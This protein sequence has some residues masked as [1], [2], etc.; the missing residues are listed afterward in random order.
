MFG[1]RRHAPPVQPL[2]KETATPDAATA[3]ASAFLRRGSN[4]SLSSAAAAAALRARP[5]TPTNVAEVQTRRAAHRRSP[6]LSS[7]AGRDRT[8]SARDVR[9]S[10]SVSSMIERSF[11]SPSP[12]RSPAP[13]Q[14]NVPPVPALPNVHQVMADQRPKPKKSQRRPAPVQTQPFH[15][16]SEKARDGQQG[17]WF[18]RAAAGDPANVRRPDSR[19]N[20]SEPRPGSVSPSIN[21]SYP[22]AMSPSP[23]PTS[24]L[25]DDTPVYDAHTR[26]MIPKSELLA[27]SQSVREAAEKP[28]RKRQDV[29]RTGSHLS[30]GTVGRTRAPSLESGQTMLAERELAAAPAVPSTVVVA[31]DEPREPVARKKKKQSQHPVQEQEQQQQQQQARDDVTTPVPADG[32]VADPSTVAPENSARP[33]PIEMPPAVQPEP[34]LGARRGQNRPASTLAAASAAVAQPNKGKA[35]NGQAPSPS[36]KRQG[37]ARVGREA[38]QSPARSARF[39]P[40]TEQLLVRHE[41]P[42]RSVS[43]KK[44]AM[45]LPNPRDV[46]PS[47][48]DSDASE[49]GLSPQRADDPAL[50]RKK[51]VR[52]SWDDRNTVVVGEASRPEET[53]PAFLPVTQAK[54]P[55]HSI[56]TKHTKKEQQV[57]VREDETMGPRPALPLFGS[58]REKKPREA[59]ERALVRPSER[60]WSQSASAPA[61]AATELGPSSDMAVGSILA[62][63]QAS[64]NAANISKYREPLPAATHA[65]ADVN[66]KHADV[67][68]ESSDDGLDTDATTELEDITQPTQ[69]STA[70]QVASDLSEK[71]EDQVQEVQTHQADDGVPVI[72]VSHPSPHVDRSGGD[73]LGIISQP[74]LPDAIPEQDSAAGA[75]DP[76]TAAAILP[77]L[78]ALDEADAS[79]TARSIEPL[80]AASSPAM[81]DIVEEDEEADRLS[82]YS[83]ACEDLEEV[84]GDGFMSLDAVVTP[85]KGQGK[86]K[87]S[88]DQASKK[89]S[90]DAHEAT[91]SPAASK[92]LEDSPQSPKDWENAK[93]YWKSLSYNQRRQLEM[94]ALSEAGDD[95]FDDRRASRESQKQQSM[96]HQSKAAA[97]S[98]QLHNERSYQIKPGTRWADD[99]SDKVAKRASAPPNQW[100]ETGSATLK[101]PQSMRAEQPASAIRSS[102]EQPSGMRKSMRFGGVTTMAGPNG[103]AARRLR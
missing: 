52:V 12:G 26:R 85:P 89:A 21:F 1:S 64:K 42:P 67:G 17:A 68:D 45:K 77:A 5:M 31:S 10:P 9:R 79:T 27:R 96:A 35:T 4:A 46:S 70:D 16:A 84:E 83:D 48:D 66:G 58:V 8:S 40:A 19:S 30:R 51:S 15:T 101:F 92:H 36:A 34:D 7:L 100:S 57:S 14:R 95:V 91:E 33:P 93:A 102:S 54:K 71:I 24:P 47:G 81:E 55:W 43:P 11:R 50:G 3:A 103:T 38:S 6:S 80:G 76:E 32:H 88:P 94:E 75:I 87:R 37:R 74:E 69:A 13:V 49:R 59:E 73:H 82:V 18:G 72:A 63:E 56:V 61:E 98:A 29:V 97:Q 86:S 25:A 53:Q 39:A 90:R 44:S 2:T 62:Q 65:D 22:R 78:A 60:A 41:P 23:S 20:A 28:R 99:V